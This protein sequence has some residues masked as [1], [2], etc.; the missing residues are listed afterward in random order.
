MEVLTL[1]TKKTTSKCL[2]AGI[3]SGLHMGQL[4]AANLYYGN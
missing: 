3:R 1:L 4:G 2:A